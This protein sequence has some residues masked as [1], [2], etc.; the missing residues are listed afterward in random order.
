MKS[1]NK[2][3]KFIPI[4]LMLALSFVNLF[5][6]A[7]YGIEGMNSWP[8]FNVGYHAVAMLLSIILYFCC[9]MDGMQRSAHR[10]KFLLLICLNFLAM[11][12]DSASYFMDGV[13]SDRYLRNTLLV[14]VFILDYVIYY[15][16]LDYMTSFQEIRMA[17]TVRFTLFA[18][19]VLMVIFGILGIVNLFT[20]VYFRIDELGHYYRMPLYILNFL[21][22]A[23][24]NVVMIAFMILYRKQ[25]KRYKM[26]PAIGFAFASVLLLLT[27]QFLDIFYIDYGVIL[28]LLLIFYVILNVENG[29]KGAVT[30]K[31]FATA[32]NIQASLLPSLFPDFVDVPEFE[33]YALMSPARE[34]GSDFYDFFMLDKSHFVFLIGDVSAH[35]VGGALFM[36]VSKSMLNMGSQL[37]KTPAEVLE[38]VNERIIKGDFT[39]I[40]TRV[41]LGFL[42]ICTGQLTYASAGVPKLAVQDQEQGGKFRYEY[43]PDTPALGVTPSPKYE[44]LEVTLVPGDRL[45]LFTTGILYSYR[46]TGETYGNERMFNF[47]NSSLEKNNEELCKSLQDDVHDFWGKEQQPVD[48]TMLCFTFKQP[49]R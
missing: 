38:K 35:D 17:R 43:M 47:L 27:D 29:Y 13:P 5:I 12:F 32:K 15:L 39:D 34:V 31:E 3:L 25:I 36:A 46:R 26:A 48:I 18:F 49:L 20:P 33:I 8:L 4:M 1:R 9:I 30:Q 2:I 7:S 40:S 11:A 42:D 10:R 24:V 6:F 44:N 22:K 28:L 45:F 37:S 16:I 21:Y 23:L 14:I 41:W 19:K